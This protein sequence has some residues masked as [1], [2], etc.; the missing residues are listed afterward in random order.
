MRL[1]FAFLTEMRKVGIMDKERRVN[2]R[3]EAVPGQP[4]EE[5]NAPFS[6]ENS[7]SRRKNAK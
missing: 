3:A 4:D 7:F 6:E 5:K 1:S 2:G